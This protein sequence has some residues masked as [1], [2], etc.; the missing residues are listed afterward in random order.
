[1][2]HCYC[3]WAHS[4]FIDNQDIYRA[5]GFGSM[6]LVIGLMLFFQVHTQT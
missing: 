5:F 3:P 2:L 4:N 1:M 6:P